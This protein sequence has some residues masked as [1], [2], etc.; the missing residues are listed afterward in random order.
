[1]AAAMEKRGYNAVNPEGS[2]YGLTFADVPAWT[3]DTAAT[4]NIKFRGDKTTTAT[5]NHATGKYEISQYGSVGVDGNTGDVFATRNVLVLNADQTKIGQHSFY[6][7]IGSGSGYLACD[8]KVTPIT[9][10]RDVFRTNFTYT[11]ADGTPADL[12]VGNSYIAVIE[13]SVTFG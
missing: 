12:G 4:V 3:G 8:G 10:H 9:W 6:D 5:Y 1:M 13:G 2:D 11:L 7:L